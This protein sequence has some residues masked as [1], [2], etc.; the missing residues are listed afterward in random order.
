MFIKDFLKK[1][2]KNDYYNNN[3]FPPSD[4]AVR[5]RRFKKILI[6]VSWYFFFFISL[7]LLYFS[8]T[9]NQANIRLFDAE[10]KDIAFLKNQPFT[11]EPDI[12]KMIDF[13][14][15]IINLEKRNRHWLICIFFLNISKNIELHYKQKYCELI[16]YRFLKPIQENINSKR[17]D[18]INR[19]IRE[20]TSRILMLCKV[21]NEAQFGSIWDDIQKNDNIISSIRRF[22]IDKYDILYIYYLNWQKSENG[23]KN[24]RDDYRQQLIDILKENMRNYKLFLSAITNVDIE[25]KNEKSITLEKLWRIRADK[26]SEYVISAEYTKEGRMNVYDILEKIEKSICCSTE[27]ESQRDDEKW[28]LERKDLFLEEYDNERLKAWEHFISNFQKGENLLANRKKFQE[29]LIDDFSINNPYIDLLNIIEK[30][31]DAYRNNSISWLKPFYEYFNAINSRDSEIKNSFNHFQDTLKTIINKLIPN[32]NNLEDIEYLLGYNMAKDV[33]S[34]AHDPIPEKS[35]FYNA[36]SF[37]N[38]IRR[39]MKDKKIS[40]NQLFFN[41]IEGPLKFM[42]KYTQK[43]TACYLQKKWAINI[44]KELKQ[45]NSKREK[46]QIQKLINSFGEDG[47]INKFIQEYASPFITEVEGGYKAKRVLFRSFAMPFKQNFFSFISKGKDLQHLLKEEGH[48][49]RVQFKEDK[50]E[51]Q[52]E[53]DSYPIPYH[54]NLNVNCEE[55]YSWDFYQDGSFVDIDWSPLTCSDVDLSMYYKE[56]TLKLKRVYRRAFGLARF[57]KDIEKGYYNINVFNTRQ[58]S[59]L[60]RNEIPKVKV[61]FKITGHEPVIKIYDLFTILTKSANNLETIAQCW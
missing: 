57:I 58:K 5:R 42:W 10:I 19:Q 44:L 25:L 1:I 37:L 32:Q 41:T 49:F 7:F 12:N 48:R 59:I 52:S 56:D 33:Y 54:T 47:Y 26:A 21:I 23:L 17:N 15:A 45:Q 28:F 55:I 34:N 22:N 27:Y 31:L 53:T 30:E 18:N 50:D 60:I 20:L 13:C 24:E 29:K 2:I 35:L 4:V 8:Y 38:S 3:L 6:L 61:Q 39:N 14:Q 11:Q 51:N 16:Q 46:Q 36:E 43:D 40:D 9:K